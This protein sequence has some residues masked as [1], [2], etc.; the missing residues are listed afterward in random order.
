MRAKAT[1]NS[2]LDRASK[3]SPFSTPLM[4]VI[5]QAM[6]AEESPEDEDNLRCLS[7]LATSLFSGWGQTKVVEDSFRLLRE[8]EQTKSGSKLL[9]MSR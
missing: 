4:Q 7:Q 6:G 8:V 9:S 1:G 3:L 2:Y 5:V